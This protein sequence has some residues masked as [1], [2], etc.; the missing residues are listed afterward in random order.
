VREARR[1]ADGNHGLVQ[2]A[3][4][5]QLGRPPKTLRRSRN[6]PRRNVHPMYCVRSLRRLQT[7]Y[8]RAPG[9]CSVRLFHPLIPAAVSKFSAFLS[10][11]NSPPSL[12]VCLFGRS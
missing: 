10:S 1:V 7:R 11:V 2:A 12:D 8:R 9:I 3:H 4:L 6:W 5:T